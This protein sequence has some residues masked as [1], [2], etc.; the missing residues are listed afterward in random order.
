MLDRGEWHLA[1]MTFPE[2]VLDAPI[3]GE[4][5]RLQVQLFEPVIHKCTQLLRDTDMCTFRM[6]KIIGIVEHTITDLA[7]NFRGDA[8][9][10]F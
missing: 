8:Q 1:E 3:G 6:R 5:R 9:C 2:S 7:A 10:I 4:R